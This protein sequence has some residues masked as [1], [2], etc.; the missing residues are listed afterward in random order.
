[1]AEKGWSYGT[2]AERGGLARSTVHHLA[3]V[4][5]IVR[6]PQPST[7]ERLAAGLEL[8]LDLI[9]SAAAEACGITVQTHANVAGIDDPDTQMII[10]TL[11]QLSAADR[12]HVAALIDSLLRHATER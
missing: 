1:M 3:T 7:L 8:P 2:V 11:G 4:D 9:R 10:A 6:M 5:R 12:S